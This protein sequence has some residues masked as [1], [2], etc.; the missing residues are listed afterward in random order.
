MEL[1]TFCNDIVPDFTPLGGNR[2]DC[3][4]VI[5]AAV[6]LVMGDHG[7]QASSPSLLLPPDV[8]DTAMAVVCAA[9][10]IRSASEVVPPP[11]G[12]GRGGRLRCRLEIASDA[13]LE[14]VLDEFQNSSYDADFEQNNM[15]WRNFDTV[16]LQ[17][18]LPD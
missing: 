4:V 11:H 5:A 3:A 15:P 17:M 1:D 2:P 16:M 13:D 14:L 10:I 7:Q 8:V 9:V 12:R 6:S 18:V